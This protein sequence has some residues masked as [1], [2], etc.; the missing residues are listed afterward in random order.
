MRGAPC[1]RRARSSQRRCST[2]W[3]A[4]RDA[5]AAM[6]GRHRRC[7]ILPG[8]CATGTT[9]G[10]SRTPRRLGVCPTSRSASCGA[11]SCSKATSGLLEPAGAAR[12]AQRAR[13]ALSEYGIPLAAVAAY[14]AEESQAFVAW[15]ARFSD[16][17][18]GLQCVSADELLHFEESALTPFPSTNAPA[19]IDSPAWRPA[20]RRWLARHAGAPLVARTA[21]CP[22]GAALESPRSVKA[23]SPEAELASIAQWAGRHLEA[24]PEF[25]AWICV[26]DLAAR[27]FEVVDA[28]DAELAPHRFSLDDAE[29]GAPYAVAGGTPLADYPPVRAALE[30]LA[31]CGGT[32]SFDQFSALLRTPELHAAGEAGTA[33]QLDAELRRVAPNEAPLVSW[34]QMAER[35]GSLRNLKPVAALSHL[36]T[37]SRALAELSGSHPMSRWVPVWIAALERGPWLLRHRWSSIEFQSAERFRELLGALAIGDRLF[38]NQSR[39]SAENVLR[40][41]AQDTPFQAQTGVP[42]IW[43]SGQLTDPWL[44]YDGLWVSGCDEQRWPPAPDPIALLPVALQRQHGVIAASA[45]AQ[46]RFAEDLQR[47]WLARAR[48]CVFSCSDPSDGR[49]ASASPLVTSCTADAERAAD[50]AEPRP[51]WLA[52]RREAPLLER[53]ID[54]QAPEFGPDERTRGVATIKAQSLC[55]FRGF[56]ETRLG[57]QPLERPLPGFNGRERGEMLHEALRII[58]AELRDSAGLKALASQPVEYGRLLR[59]SAWRAIER[60]CARRDPGSRWRDRELVRL[61]SVL[62]KWLDLELERPA[63]EVD[64]LEAGAEIARHAGLDFS[65]RVDRIDRLP[66]GSRILID[67]KTGYAGADWRGDRPDNPQLPIYSLLHRP[68][69]V[70]AAYGSVNAAQCSFVVESER[71]GIF[72]GKRATKL[73]GLPSFGALLDLW[74]DRIEKLAREFAAGHAPVDPTDSACRSCRLQG[75]CRVPSTLDGAEGE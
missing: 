11:G 20:A 56:A 50:A 44:N 41:A 13:R 47:R 38:G 18:R 71:A 39:A 24:N 27:R 53:V 37:A 64:R 8:G 4:S 55:A 68:L 74:S 16:R 69:L 66:D 54:E 45:D 23:A 17:C 57:V 70:A 34:L 26:R 25:R 48:R 52:Q 2:P 63:F 31:A 42:P 6:S 73:E 28:F 49:P 46:L 22:A 62:R 9:A 40:R 5:G 14:P 35:T 29:Q 10:S 61:D 51:H 36:T 72:P 1:S 59:Q 7:V 43:V 65:V 15:N 30:F 60:L 75:L 58:W 67:Y 3:S 19:W 12:A 32:I 21:D 33:A